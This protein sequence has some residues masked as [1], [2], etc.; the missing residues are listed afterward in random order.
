MIIMININYFKLLIGILENI[1][2]LGIF[3]IKELIFRKISYVFVL[4]FG[5][6]YLILDLL[7]LVK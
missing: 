3:Y 1:L 6:Y 4:K 2:I 7:F 5:W